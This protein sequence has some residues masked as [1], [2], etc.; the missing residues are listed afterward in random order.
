M[1]YTYR[2]FIEI[3]TLNPMKSDLVFL[4]LERNIQKSFIKM[5]K[6]DEEISYRGVKN[7]QY[8]E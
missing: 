3:T 8:K 7:E 1:V 6:I 4:S 2:Y 5:Y